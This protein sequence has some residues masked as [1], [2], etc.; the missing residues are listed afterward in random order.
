MTFNVMKSEC[1][2]FPNCRCLHRAVSFDYFSGNR[3]LKLKN[4]KWNNCKYISKYNLQWL[5]CWYIRFLL[6]SSVKISQNIHNMLVNMFLYA[7]CFWALSAVCPSLEHMGVITLPR[8]CS[9]L[10]R[11]SVNW[12]LLKSGVVFNRNRVQHISLFFHCL[13]LSEI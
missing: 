8:C 12:L 1:S 13:K 7:Y 3:N 5:A 2:H 6:L 11:E 9:Q 10:V 4:S